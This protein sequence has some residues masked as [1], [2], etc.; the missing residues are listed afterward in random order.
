MKLRSSIVVFFLLTVSQLRAGSVINTNLPAGTTIVNIDGTAD[1]AASYSGPGQEYWYQPFNGAQV[2]FQPGTYQ[3]R[4]IDPADATALY[5]NL[6]TGQLNQIYTG[7]TFNSPW[8]ENYFAFDI[9]AKTNSSETQLFDGALDPA[10]DVYGSAQAAYD[11]TVAN[12]Y[13]DKIRPAPPGR[14]T[15]PTAYITSWTFTAPESL[16]FVIPDTDVNDNAGGVSVAITSIAQGDVNFDG[17]VNAKDIAAMMKALANETGYAQ[18]AGV[19]KSELEMVGDVNS[20]GKF[21]NADVQALIQYLKAGGGSADP[22]PE[23]ST[24]TLLALGAVVL[25]AKRRLSIDPLNAV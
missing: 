11:A 6:T 17:H 9:S 19:S 25:V 7:W 3:F 12:G 8:S 23:P 20:D 14:T 18:T 1:G 24:L 5:P 16:V 4:V 2:N 10:F 15:D 22:V 21:N 13:Y